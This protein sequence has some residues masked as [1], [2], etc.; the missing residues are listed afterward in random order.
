MGMR[1]IYGMVRNTLLFVQK[2]WTIRLQI[3]REG[4]IPLSKTVYSLQLRF[5]I[6]I[7]A[8]ENLN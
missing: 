1:N 8:S 3:E 4:N 2:R 6:T 7:R 5:T